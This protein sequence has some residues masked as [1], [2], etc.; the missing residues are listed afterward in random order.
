MID[1]SSLHL[2]NLVPPQERI[3]L[4]SAIP[5]LVVALAAVTDTVN[6]RGTMRGLAIATFTASLQAD[7][8]I[9][10]STLS[11]TEQA[12]LRE[13]AEALE[14]AASSLRAEG[15]DAPNLTAAEE[16]IAL[17]RQHGIPLWCDDTALRQKARAH[18]IPTFSLLD[19]TTVLSNGST[20]LDQTMI[21]RRLA[22]HYVVDLPLTADDIVTIATTQNWA[23]GPAHTALSR[24]AWWQH[25]SDWT[26]PWLQ[27]ATAARNHSPNA[28]TDITQAAL[29]GAIEQV[30]FGFRTQRYQQ[31]VVLA[32]VACHQTG[33]TPP[34]DMLDTL[35]QHVHVDL[36]PQPNFVLTA[37]IDELERQSV[38]DATSVAHHL[39]PDINLA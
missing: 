39:L 8:T 27:I 23:L 13:Q 4:R 36:P 11:P 15:I 10:R 31:L 30:T 35:A 37:L 2:L 32:L 1:L 26:T 38:P 9:K 20:P 5:D 25:H 14:T 7:G 3:R 12:L 17:A 6:T 24:P 21:L 19:L 29:A 22:E 34:T 18:S 28:L 16:T 33:H